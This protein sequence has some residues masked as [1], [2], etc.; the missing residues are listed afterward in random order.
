LPKL[1]LKECLKA[2]VMLAVFT[3]CV[4][5][6]ASDPLMSGEEKSVILWTNGSESD[7]SHVRNTLSDKMLSAPQSEK[8]DIALEH[9]K[10][11][12]G[13]AMLPEARDFVD[14]AIAHMDPEDQDAAAL[15]DVYAGMIQLLDPAST[16]VPEGHIDLLNED[17]LWSV[18]LDLRKGTNPDADRIAAAIAEL[19]HHSRQVIARVAPELFEPALDLGRDDIAEVLIDISARQGGLEGSSRIMLMRGYLEQLRGN[20][21]TAFDFFAWASEGHDITAARARLEMTDMALANPTPA[22]LMAVRDILVRD[23]GSWRGDEIAL[24]IRARLAQV[25]EELGDI[26]TAIITMSQI[27]NADPD[28][29]EA[30]LASERIGVILRHLANIVSEEQISLSDAARMIREIEP[31]MGLHPERVL[32]HAALAD[33][34]DEN[35]FDQAARA[36][37]AL[38]WDSIL[39]KEMNLIP[40]NL[41]DR[42]VYERAKSLLDRGEAL[43]AMS[44]VERRPELHDPSLDIEYAKIELA[45]TGR[46]SKVDLGPDVYLE[47]ARSALEKGD[48]ALALDSYRKASGLT[49]IDR[50]NAIRLAAEAGQKDISDLSKG[51]PDE[52][53]IW[54][55][56]IAQVR[57][58]EPPVLTPLSGSVADQILSQSA[59]VI[60]AAHGITASN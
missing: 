55:G 32:V 19:P 11:L 8:P 57:A 21:E 58:A 20:E 56:D 12:I 13:W 17:P 38:I 43:A 53:Q 1:K 35:G 31:Y 59:K 15:A 16:E 5:A 54:I 3:H 7:F 22:G 25:S 49:D 23:I 14:Y 26:E 34:L 27:E 41:A 42:I 46:V 52:Q 45:T 33:R 40:I 44:T 29:P 28:T 9:A 60:D 51:L 48:D 6:I 24:K 4:P 10:F 30:E 39:P 47:I 36:E 18:L 2:G 37:Y 50:V